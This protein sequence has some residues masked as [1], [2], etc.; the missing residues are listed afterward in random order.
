MKTEK[1]GQK[2]KAGLGKRGSA[3]AALKD[4]RGMFSED[5]LKLIAMVTML[6]DHIGAGILEYLMRYSLAGSSEIYRQ[7]YY[8]DRILRGIGRL[9]FPLF[10]F[11]LVQGFLYTRSR[12]KY[13]IR[14]AVFALLSEAPFDYAFFRGFTME[15]QN[16]FW[17]LLL[18]LITL[19]AIAAVEETCLPRTIRGMAAAGAVAAGMLA[20]GLIHTDYSW[21]GIVMIAALYLL[22][23]DRVLQCVCTPVLF[24]TA[25]F[26]SLAASGLDPGQA[27]EQAVGQ[28]TV[29]LSF[30]FIY[31]CNGK[32][33]MR[34]GKYF[35]YAFYPVHLLL[36]LVIR[37][38][39]VS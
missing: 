19:S 1:I 38:L 31:R 7:L 36:L 24:L 39:L 20:A 32:R 11:L 21:K 8:V 6:I 5:A 4:S 29:F 33:Y 37:W 18:G 9:S 25:Q 23:R 17:T 35:F 12:L 3:H 2:Q 30:F 27:L 34:K 10:C 22:R 13:G 28:C 15:Y 26:I 14:L 16:V